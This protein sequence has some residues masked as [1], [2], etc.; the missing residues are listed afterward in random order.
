[1]ISL[2]QLPQDKA[3][4]FV[5]GAVLFALVGAAAGPLWALAGVA[6]AA[7]AKEVYDSTGRGHVEFADAAATL[8]GG[9]T[10]FVC[11]YF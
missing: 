1:M 6:A 9:A 3:N 8:A 5:Y 11:T 7:V 2:P 4:H 10:C